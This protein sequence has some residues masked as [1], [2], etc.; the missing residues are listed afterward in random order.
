MHPLTKWRTAK[1]RNYTKAKLA[2]LLDVSP[3][4]EQRYETGRVPCEA[5]MY[6]IYTLTNGAVKPQDFYQLPD[7]KGYC[8][9]Q[10]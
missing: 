8:N 3:A 9:E 10:R 2:A 1:K 4:A 6:R 7:L 5:V